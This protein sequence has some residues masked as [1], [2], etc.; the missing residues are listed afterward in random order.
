LHQFATVMRN[1][2]RPEATVPA[3]SGVAR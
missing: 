2:R 3:L 1:A